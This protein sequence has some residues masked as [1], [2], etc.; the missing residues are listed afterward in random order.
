MTEEKTQPQEV[1]CKENAKLY[2]ALSK[3]QG[4]IENAKFNKVNPHFKSKYTDLGGLRD[5]YQKCLSKYG[6]CLTQFFEDRQGGMV[7]V[8]RLAHDSGEYLDSKFTILVGANE[9][10]QQIGSK[11]TYARRFSIGS[12]TGIGTEEDDDAN[13][14]SGSKAKE[15]AKLT[16]EQEEQL[17]LLYEEAGSE[18]SKFLNWAQ[19]SS[20]K[21][22]TADKFEASLKVLN[23]LKNGTKNGTSRTAVAR[24]A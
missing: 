22:I 16:I 8:T 20:V 24:M 23:S 10:M 5:A 4:E 21:E 9:T 18:Q 1:F 2:K 17:R 12:I 3:A 13:C 6:L 14:V 15:M 19:A 11:I 7:L